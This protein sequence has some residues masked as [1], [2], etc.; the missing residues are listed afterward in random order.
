MVESA[1]DL[2]VARQ[3]GT[4]VLSHGCDPVKDGTFQTLG[5][6][7]P[8]ARGTFLDLECVVARFREVQDNQ[9]NLP[10]RRCV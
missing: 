7:R 2:D 5:V 9:M 10:S 8:R 4:K 3:R 6:I 1:I